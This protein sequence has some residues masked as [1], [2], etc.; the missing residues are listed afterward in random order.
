MRRIL[1]IGKQ[2]DIAIEIAVKAHHGQKDKQGM[3]YILHPLRVMGNAVSFEDKIVAVLHDV[4][5]DASVL[6]EDLILAGIDRELVDSV[7]ALTRNR[8]SET[9]YEYIER[10]KKDDRA[11]RIKVLDL[12]DNLDRISALASIDAEKALS[13]ATRYVKAVIQISPFGIFTENI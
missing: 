11:C 13:L 1:E 9:Y 4:I 6:A 2:L 7:I 12:K 8:I 10:V 5:E 3:P